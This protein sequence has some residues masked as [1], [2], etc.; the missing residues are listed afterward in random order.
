[1]RSMMA[2]FPYGG[3]RNRWT[4]YKTEHANDWVQ[5]DFPNPVNVGRM[6]ICLWGDNGGVHAP[7]SFQIQYWDGVQ[8]ANVH[9]RSRNPQQPTLFMSN[10]VTIDPVQTIRL[11]LT[12]I[13]DP[14]GPSGLTEWMVWKK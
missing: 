6:E 8:W 7:K 12:F 11:R 3:P 14:R 13:H 5:L 1:M 9:E 10:E 2:K 4:A